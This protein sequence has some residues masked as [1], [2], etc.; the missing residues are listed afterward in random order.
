MAEMLQ[1]EGRG[2]RSRRG[3]GRRGVRRRDT[4]QWE[5][6]C[7][8]EE[9]C[10]GNRGDCIPQAMMPSSFSLPIS[11]FEFSNT[12]F[13]TGPCSA[14]LFGPIIHCIQLEFV[15]QPIVSSE[16]YT[17]PNPVC[18]CRQVDLLLL[19]VK[20]NDSNDSSTQHCNYT[21]SVS[22]GKPPKR[23][24]SNLHSISIPSNIASGGTTV[25][26]RASTRPSEEEEL[27][28]VTRQYWPI[29]LSN[30]K[31]KEEGRCRHRCPKSSIYSCICER[32]QPISFL[33]LEQRTPTNAGIH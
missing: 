22:T 30:A 32:I 18:I 2:G 11:A 31:L 16:A 4:V 21:S 20:A 7:V 9:P 26:T 23:S 8:S 29:K 25:A 17:A 13:P 3:P 27:A 14:S 33:L 5:C 15:L 19:L 6:S 10:F 28:A 24:R 1:G 12:F